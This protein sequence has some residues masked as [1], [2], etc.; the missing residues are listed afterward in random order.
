MSEAQTI[1]RSPKFAVR[2]PQSTDDGGSAHK[3]PPAVVEL[4]SLDYVRRGIG[5]WPALLLTAEEAMDLTMA[6]S[7]VCAALLAGTDIRCYQPEPGTV[8]A[9]WL[10]VQ[11][12]EGTVAQD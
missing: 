10:E 8:L 4:C 5:S 1:Y 12:E 3:G 9:E 11:R 7:W 6:V 2:I